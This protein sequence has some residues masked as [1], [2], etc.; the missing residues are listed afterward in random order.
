MSELHFPAVLLDNVARAKMTVSCRDCDSIPK[1][2]QAGEIVFVDGQQIQIMHNGVRVIAGGYYG[3][4]MTEIIRQ[5]QGH[6]EPQEEAIFHEVLKHLSPQ[7]T[8][9]ELGGFWSYYS[10]WFLSSHYDQRRAIVVEPDPNHLSVGRANADLNNREITFIQASVGRES[11]QI[12][13]FRTESAGDIQI[14][15]LSVPL[16]LQEYA[17]PF[18]DILHCDTQGAETEIIASCETLFGNRKIRFGVFSTHSHHISGDPLTH[19]RCLA[20]LKDFGGKIL[21]EHDVHESF[22][23]DGL[24]AAHFGEEQINW[25]DPPIT[26]N[27]YSTSLFR[28][29]L[30]DLACKMN[31]S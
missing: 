9:L 21:A 18:L 10:L 28:N 6:H 20:M 11:A 2:D 3:E 15:Q 16:F 27:R 25:R 4:W 13:T 7:A 31:S 5:L 26:R 17:I 19:Q 30:F 23:G 29:P 24:I 14:P 8:M 1:V 22:S 12:Q